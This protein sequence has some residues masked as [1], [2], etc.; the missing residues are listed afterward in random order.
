MVAMRALSLT[1]EG[2][3][4]SG[5]ADAMTEMCVTMDRLL[6]HNWMLDNDVHNIKQR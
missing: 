3:S 5:Y 1:L 4:G 6:R 2:T